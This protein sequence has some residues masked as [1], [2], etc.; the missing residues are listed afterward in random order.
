M[1]PEDELYARGSKP[2]LASC[3]AKLPDM[4]RWF[5]TAVGLEVPLDV[6]K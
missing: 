4:F 6:K 3:E 5:Y 2:F 1:P